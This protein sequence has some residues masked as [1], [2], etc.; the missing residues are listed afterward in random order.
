MR[1]TIKDFINEL[2]EVSEENTEK[3]TRI[4]RVLKD[5][6]CVPGEN[7]NG[8]IQDIKRHSGA[9]SDIDDEQ[10]EEINKIMDERESFGGKDVQFK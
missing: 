8:N 2:N 6:F 7:G 4:L 10:V 3:L 1:G 9:L 5:E